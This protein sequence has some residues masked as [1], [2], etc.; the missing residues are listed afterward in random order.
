[1]IKEIHIFGTSFSCGGGFEWKSKYY[2]EILKKHYTEQPFTQ[3]YYSWPGQLKKLLG[4][5]IKIHNHAKSGYGNERLYRKAHKIIETNKDKLDEMLFLFEFSALGRKELWSNE[6]KQYLSYNYDCNLELPKPKLM[7]VA[8]SYENQICGLEKADY[9]KQEKLIQS[10][11]EETWNPKEEVDKLNRNIDMFVSYLFENKV[12]FKIL[13]TFGWEYNGDRNINDYKIEF[14][15]NGRTLWTWI[16]KNKLTITEETN[17]DIK[18]Y[19]PSFEC[20]KLVA[21]KIAYDLGR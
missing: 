11:L 8:K 6:H 10:F 17:G 14:D 5:D 16:E 1:M 12:N 15:K 4:D 2:S 19:H 3:H 18:N 13:E 9:P 20:S 21:K 7:G